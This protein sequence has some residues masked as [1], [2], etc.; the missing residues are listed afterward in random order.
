[1]PGSRRTLAAVA[2]TTVVWMLSVG[3]ILGQ[4]G[5]EQ[6]PPMAEEVFKNIQ[7]LKGIPVDEFMGTMGFF[8]ASLGLNCTDCHV[9]ESGGNWAK[10]A[11]DNALKQTARRMMRMVA[12]LNQSSFGGRQ[13]VTCNTCHRGNRQPNVMPSLALLYGTPPPDEP[14]EPF[15][16]A[17]GQPSPD[18]VLDKY[19]QA[20]GGAERLATLTSFV[21]RG[22]YLGFD[23]A[24]KSALEILARAPGQSTTIVHRRSGDSIT[25]YDGRTGWIAAPDTEKPVPLLAVTGQELDG[26]K[27]EAEL[28]F[29]ARI[30]Q[31]LRNWR[32]GARIVIDDREVQPVQGTTAQGGTATL[33]FDVESGLLVRLVRF[34]ESP[35]GRIV[36]Q[37]DY[38]D[39]RDV[40][41]V[42]MP[43]RKTVSWL[44][45]RSTFELGDVQPNVRI[46]AA[47]FA[48]P[49]ARQ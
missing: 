49:A 6:K 22:T 5:Q 26:V 3:L 18:Q 27:L 47:R 4:T 12:A 16:Q 29:P 35:V 8:S 11:D 9:D 20:L 37:T 46:D 48:R 28:L 41:G 39:Y 33:C 38:A 2:T 15:E 34:T 10:Y 43:F 21:A 14:G 23:D 25:T 1:M 44:D 30:K 7:V 40:S 36:T 45:G 13:V 42:K 31:A 19:V 32:V 17:P 24:A